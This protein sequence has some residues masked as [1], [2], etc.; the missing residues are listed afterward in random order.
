MVTVGPRILFSILK[1]GDIDLENCSP[2]SITY[3]IDGKVKLVSAIFV[4]NITLRVPSRLFLILIERRSA[5]SFSLFF[6][7]SSARLFFLAL[8]LSLVAGVSLVK[9]MILFLI[10]ENEHVNIKNKIYNF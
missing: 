2:L 8:L 1:I 10:I 6:F 9:S 7:R 4:Q 3:P 5:S